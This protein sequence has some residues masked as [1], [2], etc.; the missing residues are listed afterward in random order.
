MNSNEISNS[1]GIE[2]IEK[3]PALCSKSAV[4]HRTVQKF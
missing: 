2:E 4:S 3:R 1:V